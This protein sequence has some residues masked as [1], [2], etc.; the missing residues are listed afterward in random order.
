MSEDKSLLQEKLNILPTRPG[1]YLMKDETGEII[2]IG[3]ATSLRQR[4]RSYFQDSKH[5]TYKTKVLVDYIDDLDYIVTDN[6][7][8]ALIL[9]ANLIKKHL[10]KFN[11]RL[12]D[13]KTYPYIKVTLQEDFPRVFKT[14]E[15][16]K[17]G[18]LY[19]GPYTDV[20]AVTKT[21]RALQDVFPI[22]DCKRK[23]ERGKLDER[24]CLN[25]QIDK[26]SGP[27]V[28]KIDYQA[29]RELVDEVILFLQGKQRSLKVRVEEKMKKAAAELDFEQAAHYR[30]VLAAL[31]KI[32]EKQKVVLDSTGDLD[33]LA[34]AQ[35]ENQ[36]CAYMF[37]VRSGRLVGREKFFL[38]GTEEGEE[39]ETLAAFL[40]QYYGR[41]AETPQEILVS[42]LPEDERVIRRWLNELAGRKVEMRI[43]LRGQKKKLLDLVARNAEHSL[44]QAL[45]GIKQQE[46]QTTVAV[47]QLQKELH[48][49]NPPHR[50]EGFDISN[51]QGKMPVASMVVFAGGKPKKEDYRRFQIRGLDSPDDFEMMSQVIRRRYSR[52]L[53]EGSNLPD[54]ILIDGG[55]GQVN[56]AYSVLSGLGLSQVPMVG[57][58]K[59][60]EEV[61]LPGRSK[62]VILSRRSAAL[63]LLQRVR[64]EAH[65][66]AV[67]Y[68]R[69]LRGR[70][71]THSLLDEIPGVGPKR[72]QALLNH[73]GSLAKIRQASVEEL[74]AV[75]GINTGTAEKIYN[76]LQKKLGA[77]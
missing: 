33:A 56:S 60:E 52:I 29:Y 41:T 49:D 9:E 22:R 64:D 65:R 71:L 11:V 4:V 35:K 26:C 51:I 3:K 62:P 46:R 30:D 32:T 40:K 21:L 63:H 8:E 69:N 28:G 57:L 47:E 43:P 58:A 10:P 23:L 59:K 54:L 75:N 44:G 76:F 14:R 68:H 36:A 50:I 45:L 37:F 6:E 19:F 34:V 27:C 31:D 7:V 74:S 53:E 20:D 17:D 5:Q 67:S 12:K 70:R 15:V 48:L 42:T 24:A 73:F 77:S 25:L 61:F 13:D 16:R 39:A 72:R 55:K 38:E 2:Y 66:F 1:V 18:A